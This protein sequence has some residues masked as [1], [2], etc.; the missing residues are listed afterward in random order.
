MK[1][2]WDQIRV[3]EHLTQVDERMGEITFMRRVADF[4]ANDGKTYRAG[5]DE[6]EIQ[7]QSEQGY[8]A[9][10]KSHEKEIFITGAA[11]LIAAGVG[12]RLQRNRS[13]RRKMGKKN[14]RSL[15]S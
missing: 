3:V 13:P 8:R 11:L 10:I 6:I 12:V 7:S 5:L 1:V 14:P 4:L 2:P 15:F 9:F